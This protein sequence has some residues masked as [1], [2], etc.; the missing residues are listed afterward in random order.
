MKGKEVTD[1][2]NAARD[3][4]C[5]IPALIAEFDEPVMEAYHNIDEAIDRLVQYSKLTVSTGK[6][7]GK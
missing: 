1:K 5:E 4:I 2:L 7:K 3:I 6:A